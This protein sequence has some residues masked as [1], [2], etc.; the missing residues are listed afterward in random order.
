MLVV[1]ET[2]TRIV[3]ARVAPQDIDQLQV[4]QPAILRF[5]ALNQRTTPEIIGT[6]IRVSEDI[7]TDTR[8]GLSYLHGADR[9]VPSRDCAAWGRAP[10][11]GH[12][13]RSFHAYR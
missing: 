10:P 7:S 5:S 4:G 2:D 9:D 1:P 6:V 11:T 13:R 8:T 12:A 3:E